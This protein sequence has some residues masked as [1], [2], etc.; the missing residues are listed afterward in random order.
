MNILCKNKNNFNLTQAK[1]LLNEWVNINFGTKM[2]EFQ[3][4]NIKREIFAEIYLKDNIE[5]YKIYCFH[6]IPKFIRVQKHVEGISGKIN[7]YYDLDWKLNNIETGLEGF[8]RRPDI[9]FEKP[10]NLELMLDY[11]KKLSE[12]LVFVRVDL[13]NVNGTIY[14][15]EMTFCPSNNIF[16]L[17][18]R[19]QSIE[20]GK[21]ID[22]HK[23]KKEF[24]IP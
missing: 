21:L 3:Y 10:K 14:L 24:F 19:Q 5:D 7:N 15:G 4:I 20:I 12:D 17:K 6:G 11:A 16:K 9:I 13:Y 22:I 18:N 1:I 23:I 2:S 8:H